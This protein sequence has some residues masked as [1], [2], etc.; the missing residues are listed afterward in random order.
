MR[1]EWWDDPPNISNI[2][3]PSIIQMLLFIISHHLFELEWK[4]AIDLM[5][6]F[7]VSSQFADI[8]AQYIIR[9]KQALLFKQTILWK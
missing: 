1:L 9:V 3:L 8:L 6:I 5:E 4:S 7:Y 2:L